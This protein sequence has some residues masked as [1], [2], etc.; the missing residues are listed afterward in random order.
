V[1]TS[2]FFLLLFKNNNNK[3]GGIQYTLTHTLTMKSQGQNHTIIAVPAVHVRVIVIFIVIVLYYIYMHI[4]CE[5]Y[6][7]MNLVCVCLFS[8]ETNKQIMHVRDLPVYTCVRENYSL[9]IIAIRHNRIYIHLG[10][11]NVR[12][13]VIPTCNISI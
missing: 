3:T 9:R 10:T 7:D 1:L 2:F 6:K 8:T 4:N 11:F 5:F 12:Q 13:F